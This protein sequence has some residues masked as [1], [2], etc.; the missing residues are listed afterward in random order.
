MKLKQLKLMNKGGNILLKEKFEK[1]KELMVKKTEGN[2]KRTIENLVVFLIILIVTIIAINL[3]W[4]GGAEKEQVQD[5]GKKLATN[6]KEIV[7]EITSSD[8]EKSL[9]AVLCKIAGVGEVKVLITY[10][11]SS[12]IIPVYNEDSKQ[13]STKESDT[14]RRN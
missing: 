4:S 10:S 12:S 7:E 13:T 11:E 14:R 1:V 9:E 8:L 6:Q 2:K 3:I 5:A